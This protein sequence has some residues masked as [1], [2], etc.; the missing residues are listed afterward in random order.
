MDGVGV[1]VG[2]RWTGARRRY[3]GGGRDANSRQHGRRS[4]APTSPDVEPGLVQQQTSRLARST[5]LTRQLH[6]RPGLTRSRDLDC[7][8]EDVREH[9]E[10]GRR[11]TRTKSLPPSVQKRTCL[12]YTFYPAVLLCSSL[13]RAASDLATASLFVAQRAY[14]ASVSFA[15]WAALDLTV[16][17]SPTCSHARTHATDRQRSARRIERTSTCRQRTM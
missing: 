9:T 3:R 10:S 8:Y 16:S 14:W 5:R 17:M 7:S 15:I 6:R 1:G 11:V 2:Q 13:N 12:A 4:T